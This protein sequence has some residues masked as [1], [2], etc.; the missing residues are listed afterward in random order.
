MNS[1]AESNPAPQQLP[2]GLVSTALACVALVAVLVVALPPFLCMPL[3]VDVSFY[4]H[5]AQVA[6]EGGTPYRDAFDN[7]FPGMVWIHA[8]LRPIIGWNSESLRFVDITVVAAIGVMLAGWARRAGGSTARSIW[9]VVAA[10]AFHLSE[11]EICHCQRDVWMLL[12]SLAALELRRRQVARGG[13]G[14][15][16]SKIVTWGVVEGACWG[17]GVWIKPYVFVPALAVWLVSVVM[18]RRGQLP[19]GRHLAAD[20][21]GLLTG[22]L[23]AGGAGF[24]WLWSTGAWPYFWSIMLD[25]NREYADKVDGL[26]RLTRFLHWTIG[27]A[28]WSITLWL[29][30]PLAIIGLWRL[31]RSKDASQPVPP[32]A[33]L[34]ALFLSW[35]LQS[36]LFQHPHFY[37]LSSIVLVAL[38][39]IAAWTRFPSGWVG[40]TMLALFLLLAMFRAPAL[41]A[42]RLSLWTRCLREG[43]TY[44][45]RDRLALVSD[46]G[47]NDWKSMGKVVEFLQSQGVKD[48]EI[49]CYHVSTTPL[50]TMLDVRSATG[51]PFVDR[52]LICFPSKAGEVR[53][54]LANSH[55]RFIVSDL[56]ATGLNAEQARETDPDN[57][58]AYPSAFRKEVLR[59]YPWKEPVV[60]RAG[61]Y[62]VHKVTGPP[63]VMRR[64]S[65]Q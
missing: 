16:L 13:A 12:V 19:S 41:S 36:A 5:A 31:V 57:T 50:L 33:L 58:T 51:L 22:G 43:S 23:A 20:F 39:V 4:D 40:Y 18:I 37:V 44:E 49:T 54:L 45:M 47:S 9:L 52:M 1:I 3:W 11:P 26:F 30:A 24:A 61:R 63:P 42:S 38:G 59:G 35:M 14:A 2:A 25:W 62:V 64:K 10:V 15:S 53:D 7:N 28:P 6:L 65:P 48:G 60:F 46:I 55:Q 17:I 56:M 8:L 32:P 34:W 21:A 29:A 27:F